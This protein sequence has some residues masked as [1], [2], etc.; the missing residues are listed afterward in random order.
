MINIFVFLFW[1]VAIL[2][3][4]HFIWDG[5][6]APVLRLR[7][8]FELFEIRD[9][10]RSEKIVN[11]ADPDSLEFFERAINSAIYIVHNF[12]LI[13][14]LIMTMAFKKESVSEELNSIEMPD[15]LVDDMS[16]AQSLVN[17][18]LGVNSLMLFFYLVPVLLY[19]F[20]QLGNFKKLIFRP[21]EELEHYFPKSR[22]AT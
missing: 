8:R 10:I 14:Y 6:I 16:K 2:A 1:A 3:F 17:S 15:C 11:M 9:K 7:I 18:A 19:F 21:V 5:L 20:V 22:Y 4:L 12:G 13:D